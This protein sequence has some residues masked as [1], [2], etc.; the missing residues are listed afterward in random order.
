MGKFLSGTSYDGTLVSLC[1]YWRG[2]VT[3]DTGRDISPL[4]SNPSGKEQCIAN[5]YFPREDITCFNSGSCNGE[6]KCITCSKYKYGGTRLGISHSPP[7][8]ILRF[9]N[10]GLSDSDIKSPNLVRFP[11]RAVQEVDHDQMP[12][13]ILI[14]NVQAEISKCC[15]W[16]MGDGTAGR[17]F[18]AVVRNGPDTVEATRISDGQLV[19]LKGLIIT[20]SV[21]D[22]NEGA[23]FPVGS[24]VVAGFEDSP[25][26][27][28][29]PRTGLIKPGEDV[30][31]N[32]N[33]AAN[34]LSSATHRAKSAAAATSQV[35]IDAVNAT[36]Q[37]CNSAR[38]RFSQSSSFLNNANNTGNLQQIA[39]ARAK[40]D[41]LS[42][43]QAAACGAASAAPATGQEAITKI[44]TVVTAST[45]DGTIAAATDL[46]TTLD[47]LLTFVIIAS[48][49]AGDT[50]ARTVLEQSQNRLSASIRE[51]K[52]SGTG[53]FTKCEFFTT[54]ENI[55]ATWNSPEDGTLPCNGVR[56]DCPFYTGKEW[57][58]AAEERLSPGQAVLAEAIQ[59]VRYRSDDWS[60]FSDPAQEFRSRFALPF[61]WAFKRYVAVGGQPAVEDMLL[62]RPKVLYARDTGEDQWE[63]MEIERVAVSSF[64][65]EGSFEITKNTSRTTPGSPNRD[66]ESFTDYPSLIDSFTVPTGARLKVTHPAVAGS[67]PFIYRTWSPDK[68]T[69]TL[70]GTATPGA[71]LRIVNET[72]LRNRQRYHAQFGTVDFADLPSTLPGLPN[73]NNTTATTLEDQVFDPMRTEKSANVNQ[74]GVTPLGF[75]EISTAQTGFWISINEVE[76]VHNAINDIYVIL[77]AGETIILSEKIQ[78]DYRFMHSIVT[79]TEF[80]GLDFTMVDSLSSQG[81]GVLTTDTIGRAT[82]RANTRPLV[83][84]RESPKFEYGYY[85]LRFKN[86]S[87]KFGP[88]AADNDLKSSNPL[89]DQVGSLLVEEAGPSTFISA[90]GYQVFQYRKKITVDTWYTVNDCGLIMLVLNDTELHR[91]LP[92]PNQQGEN[93]PLQGVLVNNG[94]LGSVVAQWAMEKLEINVAGVVGNVPLVQFYR[95]PDGVGLPANYVLVGPDDDVANAFGRPE[96]GRDTISVTVTF[97]RPQSTRSFNEEGET[98]S[99]PELD[100]EVLTSNFH[101]DNLR[102]YRHTISFDAGG[103]LVAGGSRTY[104]SVSSQA[105][106]VDDQQDYCYVFSDSTGRPIGRKYTRFL[107]NYY[108][109]A[110]LNVEIFYSWTTDCEVAALIPDL[111]LA[112]GNS[113]GQT[114]A[115]VGATTDPN[116]PRLILGSRI[117]NLLGSRDCRRIPSC[118]DH[119]FISLGQPLREFEVIANVAEGGCDS[120]GTFNDDS[121]GGT[122]QKAIYVSAGQSISGEVAST[123]RPGLPFIIRL[124]PLWYPYTACERPR[125]KFVTG[126][127]LHTDST[128][129]I[130]NEGTPPGVSGASFSASEAS[131]AGP[132]CF[133]GLASQA[134]EA[135]HAVDRVTPKILD[136]HPSLNPCRSAYT[137]GNQITKGGENK[138]TG[139]GRVRGEIDTS[140]YDSIPGWEV[141]PF[142]NLGRAKIFSEVTSKRG[143][144]LG[145]PG[146]KSLGFRWMPMFPEREDLGSSAT[147]FG[148]DMEPQSYRLLCVS[149]PV[150]A[151]GESVSSSPLRYTQ[152][153]L[154]HNRVGGAIE[155]PY[156]PYYPSF[157]PDASLGSEPQD[158]SVEGLEGEIVDPITTM[159]AW[160]EQESFIKRGRQSSPLIAGV[161]LALP[162]YFIDNRRMEIRL[163]PEEGNVTLA[164]TPPT[165]TAD[166]SL[167]R[168]AEL[169][170]GSDGPPRQIDIDFKTR[171]FGLI[172]QPNTVY[173]TTKGLNSSPFPCE[174]NTPTDN[175]RMGATCS[176]I[177]DVNS[178][179]LSNENLPS[180]VLHLDELAPDGF[181]SLY[182][183]TTLNTPFAIDLS[184]TKPGRPRNLCIYHIRGIFFRIN[185]DFIPSVPILDASF[186]NRVS[187][188]YT[189]SRVP[190]GYTTGQ[191]IDGTVWGAAENR[192]D[193]FVNHSAGSIFQN[194]FNANNPTIDILNDEPAVFPSI[195][196]AEDQI[197]LG[198]SI[199]V[200]D[201]NPGDA[202]LKGGRPALDSKSRGETERI[203][204]TVDFPTYVRIDKVN[205]DFITGVGWEAPKYQLV[206][207]EPSQIGQGTYPSSEAGQTL[208]TSTQSAVESS[209]PG[210]DSQDSDFIREGRYRFS[211]SISP[212]YGSQ[213]FWNQFGKRF[214]LVFE[215]R[216]DAQSMG[217]AGISFKVGAMVSGGANT[218]IIEI[219]ERKYYRSSGTIPGN[220]NPEQALGSVDSATVYWHTV[221]TRAQKGANRH[222]AY[223][224]GTKLDDAS[225]RPIESSVIEELER[226]QFK[227][228]DTARNLMGSSP[229][230]F[231]YRSFIPLDEQDWLRFLNEPDPAWQCRLSV[232]SSNLD[233]LLG[234]AGDLRWDT[235]PFRTSFNPPGHT[236]TW[237]MSDE[238]YAGC[239]EDCP[240]Q[241]LISFK[242]LHLHDGL[243]V[244]ETA[245]F[246]DELPSGF[247]R[248]MRSTLG[249]P[250]PR[251]GQSNESG[252]SGTVLLDSRLFIDSQGNPIDTSILENAG[253]AKS[254]DGGFVIIDRGST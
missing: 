151:I 110:C 71:T 214:H 192:A 162:A 254:E 211:S 44:N 236:W 212:G 189:W 49:H 6:G 231:Q 120:G 202:R 133:E 19:P 79:Q 118:G 3:T 213:P 11:P 198:G 91:V 244:V 92:L 97:L 116:D 18:L 180:R 208:G 104:G 215:R 109:I 34:D 232:Q 62:Y 240:E 200:R 134:S 58:F 206:R 188:T 13:H 74:R 201:L 190:H 31:F 64:D 103:S 223:A 144:Y 36:A 67:A 15:H 14:R 122:M 54:N 105:P 143:D 159:W 165:F 51:L 63:T 204:L 171:K 205:V 149:T 38:T 8:D 185:A 17:F 47:E 130:N 12:L 117:K 101:K 93:P 242:Y 16:N 28:L 66:R 83:A 89:L 191:G 155:Y 183:N 238:L 9:F 229:Y 224:W 195:T 174:G 253:F 157:L 69:I 196:H 170:L 228:Y 217:I 142:S 25:S 243:A 235:V 126:G 78:I 45:K 129:L 59:E 184:T 135:Y 32:F 81:T 145:G 20:H 68:N 95:D 247:T 86:R 41:D 100:A 87:L 85:G 102:R 179:A 132:G 35:V 187:F 23:F 216:G 125:Y 152:K 136:I 46:V 39:T 114:S 181:F 61:L 65:G 176:C 140:W 123:R 161:E 239:C 252:D 241:Q 119:E 84:G 131:D 53:A 113:S 233:V 138:F 182:E 90:V 137:Y 99:D 207:V 96:F 225:S 4:E 251:F 70:M 154:I 160:R 115:S 146:G 177:E 80:D 156:V 168:P 50:G 1:T 40:A 72:A 248:I 52:Y 245:R 76:L 194:R 42:D 250:D 108:N 209:V 246:W 173:D 167:D 220:I 172:F 197:S 210:S 5:H 166:G 218:E 2:D 107:L 112:V 199:R 121:N 43:S 55:A 124:G 27:Y 33:A 88:Q 128:E 219:P 106:I 249:A 82:I 178:E 57:S 24:T 163:R 37:G 222:R 175:L 29:E 227:E 77:V 221:D 48:I 164:W 30:I 147:L 141:P 139:Y 73:F 60:R 127:P 26:F 10:K 98:E 153:A 7:S 56:T 148:E 203:I 234:S 94:G 22:N 193:G 186:D 169:K 150:G 230:V 237:G 158:R 111:F 226:L 75:D 21:F